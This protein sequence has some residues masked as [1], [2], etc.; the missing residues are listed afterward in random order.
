MISCPL[1]IE[2]V[3]RM[4]PKIAVSYNYVHIIPPEVIALLPHRIINLHISFLPYNR[5]FA[6]NI[7]SF[8]ENTPKGVTIHEIDAGLDTGAIIAQ[9]EIF[10]DEEKETLATSYDK[11]QKEIVALFKAYWPKIKTGEYPTY[12]PKI[13]GTYHDKKDLR[14]LLKDKT[15]DYDETIGEWKRRWRKGE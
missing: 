10:F 12:A 11:L 1:S 9:K 14:N 2:L 8:R 6:P 5:G 13:K 7:W 3:K 15:V 4:R